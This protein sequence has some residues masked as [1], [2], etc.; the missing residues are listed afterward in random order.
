MLVG[1]AEQV[2]GRGAGEAVDGL[3]GI[4]DDGDVA[5]LADPMAGGRA[6]LSARPTT[7]ARSQNGRLA[8]L[9]VCDLGVT[10]TAT[11]LDHPAKRLVNRLRVRE[12]AQDVRVEYH[13]LA[14]NAVGGV[15]LADDAST[16]IPDFWNLKVIVVRRFLRSWLVG[17]S[18]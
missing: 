12:L 5:R 10:P 18:H 8:G 9:F 4:A 13:G 6:R 7:R 14:L 15:V 3:V 17:F 16:E 2:V 1:K 11:A